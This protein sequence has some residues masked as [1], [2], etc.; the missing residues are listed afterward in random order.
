M[1]EVV[2]PKQV[3]FRSDVT[4]KQFRDIVGMPC[5]DYENFVI[6]GKKLKFDGYWKGGK[7]EKSD[8]VADGYV[9]PTQYLTTAD[10][11]KSHILTNIFKD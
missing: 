9:I 11:P 1:F 3:R 10:K 8:M 4:K 6:Q 5:R 7:N 2:T